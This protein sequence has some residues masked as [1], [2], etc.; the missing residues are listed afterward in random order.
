MESIT[1]PVIFKERKI[2]STED[3]KKIKGDLEKTEKQFIK[4]RSQIVPI[5]ILFDVFFRQMDKAMLAV[6]YYLSNAKGSLCQY[7]Q[8]G[9]ELN[10]EFDFLETED[11]FDLI[12]KLNPDLEE[13]IEKNLTD[14][15]DLEYTLKLKDLSIPIIRE[16][17]VFEDDYAYGGD[18]FTGTVHFEYHAE[19]MQ[20]VDR[21][22]K[23]INKFQEEIIQ[24]I[25]EHYS[26]N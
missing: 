19:N 9:F 23:N 10:D 22:L 7:S 5:D 6:C 18:E 24:R 14:A 21:V 2:D 13:Q 11:F 20:V 17:R 4:D 16:E 15:D 8:D 12:G 25:M 3:F 26:N 1:K